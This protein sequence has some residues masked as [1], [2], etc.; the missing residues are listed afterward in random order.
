MVDTSSPMDDCAGT[1]AQFIIKM[2]VAPLADSE[3]LRK[4]VPS[5]QSSPR[6]PRTIS[7]LGEKPSPYLAQARTASVFPMSLH[8][9]DNVRDMRSRDLR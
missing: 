5:E 2:P 8:T 9:A 3:N 1:V 4:L 6:R 7:L